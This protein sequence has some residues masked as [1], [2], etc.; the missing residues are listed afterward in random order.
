MYFCR[1]IIVLSVYYVDNKLR[2]YNSYNLMKPLSELWR[3]VPYAVT[4]EP[5]P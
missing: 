3:L 1:V 5:V 2:E 4:T